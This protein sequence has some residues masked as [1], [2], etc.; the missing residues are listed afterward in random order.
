MKSSTFKVTLALACVGMTF[1]G[2][3]EFV[4]RPSGIKF[5][6]HLTLKPYVSVGATYD[7]N[8]EARDGG[9]EDVLW[10]VNPGFGIEYLSEQWSVVLNAHYQYQGHSK[11]THTQRNNHSWGEELTLQWTDSLPSERGWTVA[12]SES[13]M[14]KNELDDISDASGSSYNQDRQEFTVSGILERRITDRFHASIHGGYYWLDYM[15]SSSRS[16]SLF[17]WDRWMAGGE[18]GYALSPW[19]DF[20]LVGSYQRYNQGNRDDGKA[21]AHK[22][23]SAGSQGV[24]VQGGFGTYATERISYRLLGGW[25]NYSYDRGG[26]DSNGFSYSVSGNWTIHEAWKTSL[27]A[28]SSYQP[29]EREFGSSQRVDLLSWGIAHSMVR[30]KLNASFDVT[31]RRE[32]REYSASD[33]YDYDLDFLTFRLGLHYTLNRFAG[34]YSTFEYRKSMSDKDEGRG[35]AYDYDRFRAS[36]GVRFTY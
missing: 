4:D 30:G 34:L 16:S 25:T 27:L 5:G 9:S 3:A 18:V 26:K 21:Y 23:T 8:A 35:A 29:T 2:F 19:T 17:G 10:M 24:T 32:T 33:S 22:N 7:S 1:A 31:Y 14:V 11:S 15:N 28:S 6:Q 12:L 36:V 13:F 20:L